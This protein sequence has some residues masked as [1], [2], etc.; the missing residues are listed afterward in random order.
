M[1]EL[2]ENRIHILSL[3][4]AP[5][6]ALEVASEAFQSIRI[7]AG[8]VPSDLS[9]SV[10]E[11]KPRAMCMR[12]ARCR[13]FLVRNFHRAQAK[14]LL[15]EPIDTFLLTREKKPARRVRAEVVRIL[16]ENFRCIS[17]RVYRD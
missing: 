15:G 6:K 3:N 13:P 8:V 12:G 1:T 9:V 11:D 10:Y 17:L 7:S 4:L 2:E 14:T 5:K 16:R